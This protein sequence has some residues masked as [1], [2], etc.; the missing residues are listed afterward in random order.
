MRKYAA[1]RPN[2]P[3]PS[4]NNLVT[5]RPVV[6]SMRRKPEPMDD[7]DKI[8]NDPIW[9]V[10][11]TNTAKE[12]TLW[13]D[14]ALYDDKVRGCGPGSDRCVEAFHALLVSKG[15]PHEWHDQWPGGHEGPTYWGPHIPD[16]LQWYSSVLVGQ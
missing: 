13:M 4:C 15:I 9:L 2:R 16:Y 5:P 3:R 14:V 6:A 10:Q 8:R 7:S 1:V 11:N 12:L